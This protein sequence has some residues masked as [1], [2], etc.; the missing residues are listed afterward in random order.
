[1]TPPPLWVDVA[2]ATFVVVGALAALVGSF[3]LVRLPSFFQRVHAPTLGATV[4]T[5]GFVLA[6]VL[7]LSFATGRP[8]VH[9]LLVAVFIALTTPVTTA[10]LMRAALFRARQ[11]QDPTVPS[12]D[13]VRG[14]DVEPGGRGR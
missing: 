11:R 8:F 1:M 10:L 2:T 7:Q 6:M 9:A 3:G 5:W 13:E 12:P 14:D 4:G